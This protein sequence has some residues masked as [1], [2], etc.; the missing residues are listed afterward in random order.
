MR[1]ILELR[2]PEKNARRFLAPDEGRP[3]GSADYIRMFGPSVRQ[4]RVNV[5]SR[6]YEEIRYIAS[7]LKQEKG[8]YLFHGWMIRRYYAPKELNAAELFKLKIAAVFEPAGEECGTIYDE[9]TACPHCGAGR[10]QVSELILDLRKVPKN[11]DIARTIAG[12]WIVSQRFA[13]LVIDHQLTGLELRP[14]RHKAYYQDDPIDLTKLES[15]L[16]SLRGARE[17]GYPHPKGSFWVWL[18]RAEQTLLRDQ[19]RQEHIASMQRRERKRPPRPLPQYYQLIVTSKPVRIASPTRFG[20]DPF[21]ED[22]K[23]QF[24]CPRGHVKG[25][26]VLSELSISGNTWGGSDVA[27]T[28]EFVGERRG[29]LVPTRMLM[30]SP[31]L[32]KLLR[33]E[34]IKGYEV[35][36]AHLV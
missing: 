25:L 24:R 8:E 21:D 20:I 23:G 9:S 36:V 3:L 17:A 16:E 29:L 30:I 5:S 10:Q 19:I 7:R 31:R 11:K 15:G 12:E 14:V 32:Y 6:R 4:L 34:S 18:N 13:E 26:N 1:E 28:E 22:S 27:Q 35:E 33:T 2:I